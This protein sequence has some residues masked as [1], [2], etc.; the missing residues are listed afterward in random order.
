MNYNIIINNRPFLYTTFSKK[1]LYIFVHKVVPKVPQNVP[2]VLIF[3]FFV[4][5]EDT[6]CVRF[7]Y[8]SDKTYEQ[9]YNFFLFSC[10]KYFVECNSVTLFTI[11]GLEKGMKCMCCIFSTLRFFDKTFK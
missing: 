7:P 10:F 11:F 5:R 4:Q 9:F 8:F 2:M 3:Q 6:Q 1:L